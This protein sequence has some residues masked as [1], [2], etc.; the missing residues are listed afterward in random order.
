MITTEFTIDCSGWFDEGSSCQVYTIKNYTKL[1]FKEFRSKKN[2]LDS[3][4]IHKKLSGF[5]LAPKIYSDVCKLNFFQEKIF[6]L[7]M[8]VNT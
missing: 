8:I 4:R 6:I 1:L 3:F 7:R 5:D 2:A